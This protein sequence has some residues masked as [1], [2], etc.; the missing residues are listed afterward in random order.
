M[1]PFSY[2][3]LHGL[4]GPLWCHVT[5]SLNGN[6]VKSL[7]LLVESWNLFIWGPFGIITLLFPVQIFNP[8][9]CTVGWKYSISI[10]WVMHHSNI[11]RCFKN[12]VN[13]LWSFRLEQPV[14]I[15]GAIAVNP[16][17]IYMKSR[18]SIYLIQPSSKISCFT[19]Y[20]VSILSI[21]QPWMSFC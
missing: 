13:P 11:P 2:H 7:V 4:G 9:L 16:L 14:L 17:L 19:E 1:D 8:L 5:Y 18:F 15:H 6:K 21:T 10:S 3:L 20:C 12:S